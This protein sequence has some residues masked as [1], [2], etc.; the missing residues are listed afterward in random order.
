MFDGQDERN[1]KY[2]SVQPALNA[3]GVSLSEECLTY[4][5]PYRVRY[6][7]PCAMWVF[8]CKVNIAYVVLTCLFA[9]KQC[10]TNKCKQ[11][12]PLD[13]FNFFF[14]FT[15]RSLDNFALL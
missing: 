6:I 7:I 15:G 3:L 8:T 10:R 5:Y 14:L 9:A 11:I 1:K 4:S 2:E 12:V 13:Q